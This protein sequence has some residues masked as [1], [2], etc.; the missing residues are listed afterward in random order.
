MSVDDGDGSVVLTWAEDRAPTQADCEAA[1]KKVLDA[2][3]RV[4][5]R[6]QRMDDTVSLLSELGVLKEGATPQ[7]IA[8]EEV[9]KMAEEIGLRNIM[10]I[11]S[12][13]DGTE[14]NVHCDMDSA[15]FDSDEHHS[16]VEEYVRTKL[17]DSLNAIS[18]R[19]S[20]T[21]S[22]KLEL[23]SM[24][25]PEVAAS[26][27][28]GAASMRAVVTEL[29]HD[30]LKVR[31]ITELM[32]DMRVEFRPGSVQMFMAGIPPVVWIILA[33]AAGVGALAMACTTTKVHFKGKDGVEL[34][35]EKKACCT[36]M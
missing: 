15:T 6:V 34:V 27:G 23:Q 26:A 2:K 3:D 32:Q 14:H 1:T 9:A 17:N 12:S 5:L 8:R 36:I 30:P 35:I 33:V 7:S 16:R 20:G 19:S 31:S 28:L 18:Q 4:K 10:E 24:K 22:A 13:A 29:A 11:T 25:I 21:D